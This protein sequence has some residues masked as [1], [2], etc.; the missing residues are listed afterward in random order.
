MAEIEAS[1]APHTPN[2]VDEKVFRQSSRSEENDF[3]EKRGHIGEGGD[4]LNGEDHPPI[5]SKIEDHYN[6]NV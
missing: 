5:E 1:K 6:P 3:D 4:R 2:D